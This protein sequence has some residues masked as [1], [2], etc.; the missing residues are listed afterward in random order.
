MS[1]PVFVSE[2]GLLE[3]TETEKVRLLAFYHY[4]VINQAEFTTKDISE[5]FE[6]LNLAKPNLSRLKQNLTKSPCF[7]RG[8]KF[9]AF[10]L[11]ARE[12]TKL[13]SSYP[14]IVHSEEIASQDT[15][16]PQS[17]YQVN[18]SYIESLSKQI[19]ASYEH[20]ISDGCAV[21]MRRL[22]EILLIHAYEHLKI[23]DKIKGSDGNYFLLEKI[24]QDA[25]SNSTLSLSRNTKICIE[26][27][28]TLGNFSAHKIYYNCKPSYIEEVI[29]DYRA[30]VEELLYKSGLKT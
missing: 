12:I 9:E 20:N 3:K 13:D 16:L 17:L 28:R 6:T 1:L 8:S 24:V 2:S 21:L 30:T 23:A 5:W 26:K 25:Q 22:V 18:K 7:I 29:L 11:H 14:N 10:R 27:F 4:K 19:N 15:V